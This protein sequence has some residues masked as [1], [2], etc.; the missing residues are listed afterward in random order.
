M[1]KDTRGR[2]PLPPSQRRSVSMRFDVTEAEAEQIREDA[3]AANRSVAD[4]LRHI[5]LRRKER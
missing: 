2:K 3:R 4:H 1:T 5:A